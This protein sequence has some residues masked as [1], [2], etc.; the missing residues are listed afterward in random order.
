[1]LNVQT[2]MHNHGHTGAATWTSAMPHGQTKKE[3]GRR[4]RM[5]RVAA[6]FATGRAFA[7]ALGEHEDTVNTWELGKRYPAVATLHRVTTMLK[8]TSDYLYWGEESGLT[9]ETQRR[10]S[11]TMGRRVIKKGKDI[12]EKE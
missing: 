6:G 12:R 3:F 2:S 1:M 10:L 9:I 7:E 8:V 11:I 4:L 5:A